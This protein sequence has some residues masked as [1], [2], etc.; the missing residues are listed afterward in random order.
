MEKTKHDF[1]L[2][3]TGISALDERVLDALFE[4]GCDDA[5][6]SV[7]SGRVYL[8]F[9]RRADSMKDAILSAISDVDKAQVGAQVIRV[10]RSNH[11]E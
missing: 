1:T 5:T 4:A 7:R 11:H 10:E 8:T 6:P 9:S 3:L 2:A